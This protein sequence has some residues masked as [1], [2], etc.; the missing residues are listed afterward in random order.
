MV[1]NIVREIHIQLKDREG[2]LG[3]NGLPSNVK[4]T[5]ESTNM[6]LRSVC[7]LLHDGIHVLAESI[8][9]PTLCYGCR[10]LNSQLPKSAKSI[11][12]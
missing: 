10:C 6:V 11:S 4:V 8:N 7:G 9:K 1:K 3:A 5:V 2:G 12:K